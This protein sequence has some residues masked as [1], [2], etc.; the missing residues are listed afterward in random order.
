MT[1]FFPFFL[2]LDPPPPPPAAT[3]P[4]PAA[5]AAASDRLDLM[6][7]TTLLN[8]ASTLAP[9]FALVSKNPHPML[10]ASCVASSVPTWRWRKSSALLP[11]RTM[12][13]RREP[14]AAEAEAGW[15]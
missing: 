3:A 8:A 4:A 7:L 15:A 9:V 10:R 13:G 5:P 14:L 12:G 6:F 1:H 2:A 11:T